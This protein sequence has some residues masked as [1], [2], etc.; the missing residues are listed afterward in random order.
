MGREMVLSL[1]VRAT[2]QRVWRAVTDPAELPRWS[3]MDRAELTALKV[4]GLYRFHCE[5]DETTDTAEILQ[6]EPPSCFVY[7]WSS[8][9]PEPT[10]LEHLIEPEGA[11]TRVTLCN[12]G[13]GETE[14][15]DRIYGLDFTGWAEH[16]VKLRQYVEKG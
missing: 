12:S 3:Y 8:S 5:N 16:L 11:F 4:G 1:H 14:E 9:E 6:M 2:P 13:F 7:R 10:L 15:W